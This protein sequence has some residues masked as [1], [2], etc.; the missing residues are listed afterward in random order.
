MSQTV[1]IRTAPPLPWER[2]GAVL[3]DMDGTL[4]D[5]H[6]DDTFFRETVPRTYARERGMGLDAAREAVHRAYRSVEGTLAWYDLDHWTRVLDMDIPLLKEEVAHLIRTHPRTM[7]V[8]RALRE[9]GRPVHL[10]TNAHADSLALKLRRTPIGPFLTS[11][12]S[13]HDLGRAKEE[14]AFWPLLRSQLGFRPETTLLADDSEP[15]LA[16]AQAFGIAH[17]RHIA[18]PSSGSPP[19]PSDRFVSVMDLGELLP[20]PMA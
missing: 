17:L 3:L 16:A 15:V 11:V 9:M 18:A 20:A 14:A 7:D 6:F 10:V 5:L 8:L 13:S 2:I 1:M 4:L 19:R 12:T